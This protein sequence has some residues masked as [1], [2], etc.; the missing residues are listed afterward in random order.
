MSSEKYTFI[1][2]ISV[3]LVKLGYMFRTWTDSLS[4][5]TQLKH[6]TEATCQPLAQHC[7]NQ[8]LIRV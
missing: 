1:L 7:S 8:M 2:I 5:D 4:L 3:L 6:P